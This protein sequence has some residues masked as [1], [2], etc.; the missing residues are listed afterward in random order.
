MIASMMVPCSF[1]ECFVSFISVWLAR[2]PGTMMFSQVVCSAYGIC[3]AA[4]LVLCG[5]LQVLAFLSTSLLRNWL[6]FTCLKNLNVCV[7]SP[8]HDFSLQVPN[9]VNGLLQQHFISAAG[10]L[11][12]KDL[13]VTLSRAVG[14]YG[15]TE[16]L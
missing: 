7:P 6:S 14:L 2:V 10:E 5:D 1:S 15:T 3:R 12:P 8:Q 11:V 9:P 13:T 4:D 16:T